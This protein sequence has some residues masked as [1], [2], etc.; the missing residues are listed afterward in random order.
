MVIF[1]GGVMMIYPSIKKLAALHVQYVRDP[2]VMSAVS[3]VETLAAGL[4]QKIWQKISIL[5]TEVAKEATI[6]P[7]AVPAPQSPEDHRT[8]A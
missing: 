8:V 5:D 7:A 4:S 3:D 1:L 2:V 6:G